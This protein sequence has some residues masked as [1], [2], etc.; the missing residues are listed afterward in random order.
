MA[1]QDRATMAFREEL[2]R[3]TDRF[4]AEWHLTYAAAVGV[5][6]MAAMDLH[7]EAREEEE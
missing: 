1:D 6:L 5:L 4:R 2:D 3:L 7:A